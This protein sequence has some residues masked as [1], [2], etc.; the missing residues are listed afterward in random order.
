MRKYS[1]STEVITLAG[2]KIP[3]RFIRSD[4][5][6]IAI[7]IGE[8]GLTVK[9]PKYASLSDVHQFLFLKKRW[10]LAHLNAMQERIEKRESEL[11]ETASYHLS[12]TQKLSLEKRYRELARNYIEQRVQHYTQLL[13]VSYQNITIRE[14]KTRWGSCS[15]KGTLSFHWKLILAPPKVLDYVVVH[16]T[17]HL[18]HMN[19]SEDFWATVEALMPDYKVH[20]MWLKKNGTKLS[21]T[22]EA[23]K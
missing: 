8:K 11:A 19:H 16:E 17:C 6:S 7:E 14:Q 22:Y 20:R 13:N 2:K 10:I 23:I 9:A 18:L 12:D 4:R 5:Q 3:Y 15:S 21:Q 1:E